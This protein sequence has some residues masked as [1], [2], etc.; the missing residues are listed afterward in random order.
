MAVYDLY[1]K[2]MAVELGQVPDVFEYDKIPEG[3]RRQVIHMWDEAVGVPFY[4]H[5]GYTGVV[6]K[7]YHSIVQMLCREYGRTTLLGRSIDLSVG[8]HTYA[9]SNKGSYTHTSE[10]YESTSNFVGAELGRSLNMLWT[11]KVRANLVFH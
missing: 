11:D 2:R 8:A 3:L 5:D 10:R 9:F 4:V 6:Q 7:T 1:S